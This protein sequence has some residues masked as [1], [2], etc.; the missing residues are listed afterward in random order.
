MLL[1]CPKVGR[2]ILPDNSFVLAGPDSDFRQGDLALYRMGAGLAHREPLQCP[3]E[4]K[5]ENIGLQNDLRVAVRALALGATAILN[6][7]V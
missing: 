3:R 6:Q 1:D 7:E 4:F 5:R 2:L